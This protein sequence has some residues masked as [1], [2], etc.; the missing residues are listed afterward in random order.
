M[1]G[2]QA[3]RRAL[4]EYRQDKRLSASELRTTLAS[5]HGSRAADAVEE[6]DEDFGSFAK[7]ST[8]PAGNTS[9]PRASFVTPGWCASA[10]RDHQ[11]TVCIS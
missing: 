4:I 9:T 7:A 6:A 11:L 5:T 8:R 1:D 10:D 3:A 2:H